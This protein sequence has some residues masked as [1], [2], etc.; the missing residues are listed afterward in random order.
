MRW[1]KGRP[2]RLTLPSTTSARSPIIAVALSHPPLRSIGERDGD[3][4]QRAF[5]GEGP[6]PHDVVTEHLRDRPRESH[7]RLTDRTSPP[8]SD[9]A[10]STMGWLLAWASRARCASARARSR[11]SAI[12]GAAPSA[13]GTMTSFTPAP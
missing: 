9:T 13:A 8:N 11:A 2:G 12:E 5:A 10:F 7:V 6:V 3:V 1:T 4:G